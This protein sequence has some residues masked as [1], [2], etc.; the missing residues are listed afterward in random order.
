VLDRQEIVFKI[1]LVLL[2]VGD[3]VRE[4]L[5]HPR[6]IAAIGIRKAGNCFVGLIAHHQGCQAQLGEHGRNDRALLTHHRREHMVR[7]EFRVR[8]RLGVVDRGS[9]RLLSLDRPL[10]R[11]ECHAFATYLSLLLLHSFNLSLS[12]SSLRRVFHRL[13]TSFI[14]VR[15]GVRRRRRTELQQPSPQ[16]LRRA[17]HHRLTP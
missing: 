9:E 8:T 15:L 13:L 6:L 14:L 3:L 7:C 4:L 10:L 2:S 12:I 17:N 11:I 1:L 16:R 5:T